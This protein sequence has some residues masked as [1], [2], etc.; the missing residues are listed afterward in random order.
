MLRRTRGCLDFGTTS[1]GA[2]ESR[3]LENLKY[4]QAVYDANGRFNPLK[5]AVFVWSQMH[6]GF[7]LVG[8]IA[9][10][11]TFYSQVVNYANGVYTQR[12]ID[13]YAKRDEWLR[14]SGK[15]KSE[16]YMVQP[17]RQ[18]EDPDIDNIPCHTLYDDDRPVFSRNFLDDVE[19]TNPLHA[20]NKY[21]R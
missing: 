4:R 12:N 18:I 8:G 20:A 14:A 17:L 15:L 10:G 13:S 9:V 3:R 7:K 2:Y 5:W 1:R 21:H 6:V 16:K 19:T 11:L